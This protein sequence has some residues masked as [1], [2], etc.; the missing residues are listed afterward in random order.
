MR[1]FYKVEYLCNF[2]KILRYQDV[3][4]KKRIKLWPIRRHGRNLLSPPIPKHTKIDK[5]YDKMVPRDY[6]LDSEGQ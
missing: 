3:K 2:L 6:I 5:L 1:K 4:V